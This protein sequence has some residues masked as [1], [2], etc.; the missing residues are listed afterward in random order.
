MLK[1][2][3]PAAARK[4]ESM[5][6]QAPARIQQVRPTEDSAAAGQSFA[7]VPLFPHLSE[8]VPQSLAEL[9][10][11]L[12][13]DRADCRG[14][15]ALT[16]GDV[17][18]IGSRAVN[19]PAHE[20]ARLMAH[21]AVH[22]AQAAR[23]I[24]RGAVADLEM[25]AQ[26]LTGDVLGGR[27]IR[28]SFS[29]A[30]GTELHDTP[31]DRLA[32]ERAKARLP[33]LHRF[34]D[35]WST[36]E[37]RRLGGA[38]ERK[39]VLEARRR[40][41]A[42]MVDLG[43]P[44]SRQLTEDAHIGVLNRRPLNIQVSETEVRFT[45]RFQARFEDP[46]QQG[47][48]ADLRTALAAGINQVWNQSLG[49]QVFGGRRLVVEPQVTL[50]PATA[51]R[52]QNFWLIIVRPRDDSLVN[53]PGCT[54]PEPPSGSHTSVTDPLCDGGVMSIPPR[55]V[56]L[57]GVLGHEVMHLFGLVDRYA[58]L[59]SISPSGKKSLDTDPTRETGGR[60]D[61]LGGEEGPM[62]R[63][64]LS[65]LLDRYGVYEIEESRG[66]DILRRLE[67][68]GLTRG[69]VL[70]EIHRLEEVIQL[71]HDPRSLIRIRTDFKDRMIRD[72]ESF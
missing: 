23:G 21:E 11:R 71:G 54:L 29:P 6:A 62:L 53:Y 48:L 37:A 10:I 34:L 56:A 65:Y 40:L 59:T 46:T 43:P 4:L 64:D 55:H 25:E 24:R 12:A 42:T 18:H 35:E 72:A 17:V 19:L 61:P 30:P 47:R 5:P 28:P 63:E 52:D 70:G 50:I 1:T 2:A 45:V 67:G 8:F 15:A 9:T 39:T 16:V 38:Q 14:V 13:G 49:G 68:Q 7:Q 27:P 33:L 44:G 69:A 58:L 3:A 41:D 36:R 57:P 20:F 66:L 26:A 51:A 31:Q 22:V 60:R 32:V